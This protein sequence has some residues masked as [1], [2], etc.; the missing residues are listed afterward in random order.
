MSF[1]I[2]LQSKNDNDLSHFYYLIIYCFRHIFNR[3]DKKC[4][5]KTISNQKRSAE[6]KEKI[7]KSAEI[8]FKNQGFENTS[9]DSIVKIAG[10]SKGSFYVHFNSKDEIIAYFTNAVINKIDM[11]LDSIINS[12]QDDI[13]VTATLLK[14]WKRS[15]LIK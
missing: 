11:D 2:L 12:S 5:T 13:S 3:G 9:I 4:I 14:F 10:I 8:L 15:P 6:T 7:L 1:S